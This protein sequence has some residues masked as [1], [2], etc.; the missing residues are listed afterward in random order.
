MMLALGE[1]LPGW[2]VTAIDRPGHGHSDKRRRPSVH[3][4]AALLR[5]AAEQ[6]GLVRPVVVGHSLGGAVALAYGER[7]ADEIAGVVAISPLAYPGWGPAHAGRA[8]RGAPL[9]G[10]ALSGTIQGL[11][12]PLMMRAAMRL[13]FS[14]QQPSARFKAAIDVDLLARP[15]A[16]VADGGDFVRASLDLEGLSRRY[17]EYPAPL[18]IIVGEKDR[19]LKPRRQAERLARDVP[20]AVLTVLPGLGHMVHHFAPEAVAD[21]V[22]IMVARERPAPANGALAG[23]RALEI[24]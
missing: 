21:A 22:E 15:S 14:P 18:E 7:F 10:P 20:G 12:D 9:L 24:A 8:L 1:A 19:I 11:T 2:R 13:I 4:Q 16:M 23:V 17:A 3:V 6:L 5:D